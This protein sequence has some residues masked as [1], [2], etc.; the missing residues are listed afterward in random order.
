ME[1][2]EEYALETEIPGR[3]SSSPLSGPTRRSWQRTAREARPH[4]AAHQDNGT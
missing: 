3:G 1:R 4:E 2:D